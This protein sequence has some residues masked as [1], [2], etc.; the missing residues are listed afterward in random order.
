MKDKAVKI[1]LQV[2]KLQTK[3]TIYSDSHIERRRRV[4]ATDSC[5]GAALDC[6]GIAE[7]SGRSTPRLG[8]RRGLK[9]AAPSATPEERREPTSVPSGA[10]SA[11]LHAEGSAWAAFFMFFSCRSMVVKWGEG[12]AQKL[13]PSPFCS[14]FTFFSFSKWLFWIK[15]ERAYFHSSHQDLGLKGPPSGAIVGFLSLLATPRPRPLGLI[16]VLFFQ[17]KVGAL[18][19]VSGISFLSG[20]HTTPNKIR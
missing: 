5:Q 9:G 16:W 8:C 10:S 1:T 13:G 15:R 2:N 18:G 7:R 14:C 17:T 3:S 4:E 6:A 11:R 19:T 20:T 12:S